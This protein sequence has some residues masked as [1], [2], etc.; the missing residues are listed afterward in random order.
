[1]NR[2]RAYLLC[3]CFFAA[4]AAG[5][6]AHDGPRRTDGLPAHLTKD[7]EIEAAVIKGIV[8][9][10]DVFAARLKAPVSHGVVTLRGTVKSADG[11]ATA[12]KIA[13]AVPGVRAVR[14]ELLVRPAAR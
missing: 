6:V 9:N 10:P 13:R 14:N 4:T 1:M 3:I 7:L 5:A 8:A 12:E 11:R 2:L